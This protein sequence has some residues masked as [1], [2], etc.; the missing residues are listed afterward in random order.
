MI[1]TNKGGGSVQQLPPFVGD[2]GAFDSKSGQA[3][4]DVFNALYLVPYGLLKAS[5]LRN[6]PP[7]VHY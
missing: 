1:Q 5:Q 7:Q 6:H 3:F 2:T 4:L